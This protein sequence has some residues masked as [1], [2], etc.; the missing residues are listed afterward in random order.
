M[1]C[2]G[3]FFPVF[4]LGFGIDG[5]CPGGECPNGALCPR[6]PCIDDNACSKLCSNLTPAPTNTPS[7]EPPGGVIPTPTPTP[8]PIQRPQYDSEYCRVDQNGSVL[9]DKCGSTWAPSVSI[10][11]VSGKPVYICTCN[12]PRGGAGDLCGGYCVCQTDGNNKPIAGPPAI[13][14]CSGGCEPYVGNYKGLYY[15][16]KCVRPTPTP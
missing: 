7:G 2:L 13:N 16:C 4:F 8:A 5:Y 1:L 9:E 12:E 11:I 14:R 3:G 15:Y 10:Q 6:D